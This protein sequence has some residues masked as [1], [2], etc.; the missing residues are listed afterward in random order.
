MFDAGPSPGRETPLSELS[1][2][3]PLHPVEPCQVWFQTAR[4][5]RRGSVDRYHRMVV[6]A[7]KGIGFTGEED[8]PERKASP[9]LVL[10]FLGLS[11]DALPNQGLDPDPTRGLPSHRLGMN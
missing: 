5:S 11:V 3:G 7:I 9:R 1:F 4:G 8:R 6:C 2:E 10:S